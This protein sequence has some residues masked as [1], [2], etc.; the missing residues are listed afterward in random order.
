MKKNQ[1]LFPV[2]LFLYFGL[3]GISKFDVIYNGIPLSHS[4]LLFIVWVFYER[5]FKN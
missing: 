2:I 3:K 1:L 4:V 5:I